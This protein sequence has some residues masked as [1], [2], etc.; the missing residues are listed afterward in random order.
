MVRIGPLDDLS[1]NIT[2]DDKYSTYARIDTSLK[3][4]RLNVKSVLG[5]PWSN[6]TYWQITILPTTETYNTV[7]VVN[8]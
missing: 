4:L 8:L 3:Q 1:Y 2:G 7:N 6:K 5:T